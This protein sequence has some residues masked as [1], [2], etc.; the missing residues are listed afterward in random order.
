MTTKKIKVLIIDDDMDLLHLLTK[1]LH[2]ND[3]ECMSATLPGEGLKKAQEYNPDL[4]LLDL[5][6]PKMS[7]FGFLREFK[8]HSQ[9]SNIPVVVLTSIADEDVSQE[10]LNLGA[11]TYL[12]KACSDQELLSAINKHTPSHP[13]WAQKST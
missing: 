13:Y 6:L 7:G 9:L 1:K 3:V 5:N 8:R 12:T 2:K 4:V 10:A 11:A